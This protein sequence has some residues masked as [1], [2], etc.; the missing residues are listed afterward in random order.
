MGYQSGASLKPDLKWLKMWSA[1]N[2]LGILIDDGDQFFVQDIY[3]FKKNSFEWSTPYIIL[4]SI[5]NMIAHAYIVEITTIWLLKL[6][7]KR[8]ENFFRIKNEIRC[9]F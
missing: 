5:F 6:L 8:Y 2:M 4:R 7:K 9:N 1:C 3:S